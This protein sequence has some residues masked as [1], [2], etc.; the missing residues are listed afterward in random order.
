MDVIFRCRWWRKRRNSNQW[1]CRWN[2]FNGAGGGPS[3]GDSGTLGNGGNG[4]T[5]DFGGGG[6][7]GGGYY[8][9]GGG[10]GFFEGGGGG[11]SNYIGGVS[12]PMLSQLAGVRTGDGLVRL[13]FAA[14]GGLVQTEGLPSG[15]LFPVG[16]TT[17]TFVVFDGS[18]NTAT[19]S[20]QVTVE[21]TQAPTVSCPANVTVVTSD[22]GETGDCVGQYDWDHPTADDNCGLATYVVTYTNPDGTI[23]GPFDA[24]SIENSS[25]SSAAS[26][27]FEIGETTVT[28][29]VED[30]NGNDASCSFTVTATDNEDPVFQNCPPAGF[31]VDVFTNELPDRPV[32][33]DPNRY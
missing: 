14:T 32:L 4:D 2:R 12:A 31:T 13:S 15:S 7:G 27:N 18:G 11:G 10:C 29:Y 33:A 3:Q 5:Y 17:N 22:G 21:D 30:A 19:C 26:R 1:W 28:Y 8:G 24:Y 25:P 9:G 23:D 16:T 20:F 6:G